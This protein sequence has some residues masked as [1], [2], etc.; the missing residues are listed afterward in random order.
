MSVFLPGW[1]KSINLRTM[2]E[3]WAAVQERKLTFMGPDLLYWAINMAFSWGRH[4]IIHGSSLHIYPRLVLFYPRVIT[5]PSQGLKSDKHSPTWRLILGVSWI[6]RYLKSWQSNTSGYICEGVS[7]TGWYLDECTKEDLSS[8]TVD[9][10]I[11][12]VENCDRTQRQSKGELFVSLLKL[13]HLSLSTL[14]H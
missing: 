1:P 6:T 7:R 5:S 13:G 8:P 3:E 10:T 11:Q 2:Q 14:G 12:L 9:G 4:Y